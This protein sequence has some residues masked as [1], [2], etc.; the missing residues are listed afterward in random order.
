MG[1]QMNDKEMK[2]SNSSIESQ[3]PEDIIKKLQAEL[4]QE[5]ATSERYKKAIDKATSEAAGYKK[6]LRAMITERE[7]VRESELEVQEQLKEHIKGIEAENALFKATN[8]YLSIGM[9]AEMADN[10]AKAAI[11]GDNDAVIANMQEY[12]QNVKKETFREWLGSRP[13]P[14]CGNG[15]DEPGNDAFL[16]GFNSVKGWVSSHF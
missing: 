9:P 3:T 6:D 8:Q 13:E 1:N 14:N 7:Q 11:A 12:I 5:R 16:K 4:D 2:G 15:E 10:T